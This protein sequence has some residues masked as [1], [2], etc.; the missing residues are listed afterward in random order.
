[1]RTS[2]W[3]QLGNNFLDV[4]STDSMINRTTSKGRTSFLQKIPWSESKDNSYTEEKY[5]QMHLTKNFSKFLYPKYVLKPWK[6]NN[7]ETNTPIYKW[8]K[9]LNSLHHRRCRNQIRN[10]NLAQYHWSLKK[11]KLKFL[12]VSPT[13]ACENI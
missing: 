8:P 1:M 5:L 12:Y 13:C 6:L 10:C 2:W 9:D 4:L 3:Y 11:C 7:K